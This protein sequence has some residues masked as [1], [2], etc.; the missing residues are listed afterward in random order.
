M[1]NG[2][3]EMLYRGHEAGGRKQAD[4]QFPDAGLRPWSGSSTKTGMRYI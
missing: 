2:F 1:A 4:L 3:Y